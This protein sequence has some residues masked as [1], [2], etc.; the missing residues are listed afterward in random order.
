MAVR[1]A[2]AI[3]ELIV[4]IPALLTTL[5]V[6]FKHGF[7]KQL[8]WIYLLI[9]TIVRIAGAVF[10]IL[11]NSNKS[12]N[13]YTEW[14]FILQSVGISPL[15]LASF[16]LLK[17]VIDFTS[18]H[19]R[20]QGGNI[21]TGL[22][23]ARGGL[24]AKLAAKASADSRRSRVIQLLQLPCTIALILC[25]EGGLDAASTSS[26]PSDIKSGKTDVKWGIGIFVVLYVIL[27][28]LTLYSMF[29]VKKTARGEKRILVAVVIAL[30]LIGS[31]VL[32]S[33]LDT[34]HTNHIFNLVNGN[35]IVQLFMATIEEA[36]V[37]IMYVIVGLTVHKYGEGGVLSAKEENEQRKMER[38]RMR[39][40]NQA[41]NLAEQGTPMEHVYIEQ[42]QRR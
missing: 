7:Q 12:N 32:Y 34:F 20:S 17:R 10:E 33:V 18:T 16:G 26:T 30:P 8:G 42:D 37:V 6:L 11:H 35:A 9:F 15:L 4:Y 36:I 27:A 25:I 3:V 1:E 39:R 22:L 40:N 29:E 31:R 13:T 38:R 24:I 28:I 23:G 21:I 2:I 19:T 14:A 5:A 41:R